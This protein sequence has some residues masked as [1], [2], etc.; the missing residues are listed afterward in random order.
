MA[1]ESL[2]SCAPS[3]RG[4]SVGDVR[5]MHIEGAER[6]LHLCSCKEGN[7]ENVGDK[8]LI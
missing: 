2:V 5:M 1:A 4:K 7:M 6:A 3:S 8:S